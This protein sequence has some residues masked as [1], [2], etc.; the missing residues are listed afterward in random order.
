MQW[1]VRAALAFA[2]I[3]C[4]VNRADN[5]AIAAAASF[6]RQHTKH[7][8]HASVAGSD[9][10]ILLI[11][12]ETA[13]DDDLVESIHYGTDGY[14]AFGGVEQFAHDHEFRGVVYRDASGGLWTYGAT[15]RDEARSLSPCDE[16]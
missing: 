8:L 5:A 13:F 15:T 6:T 9:C 4:H 14:D 2:L 12:I 10:Q 1:I 11:T 7:K 16:P 3:A